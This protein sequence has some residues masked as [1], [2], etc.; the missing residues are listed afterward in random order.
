MFTAA[1]L[2]TYCSKDRDG[3]VRIVMRKRKRLFLVAGLAGLLVV[4]AFVL[5]PRPERITLENSGRVQPGMTLDDVEAILGPPGDYRTGCGATRTDGLAREAKW[6]GEVNAGGP[7][8][9]SEWPAIDSSASNSP[10]LEW[11]KYAHVVWISDFMYVDIY[12][13]G[14]KLVSKTYAFE[15]QMTESPIGRARWWAKRLWRRV[16]SE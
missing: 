5:L 6:S 16:F 2:R 11:P 9:S 14:K 4:G 13:D 3:D 1:G 10:P 8:W 12:F 7:T 15:R